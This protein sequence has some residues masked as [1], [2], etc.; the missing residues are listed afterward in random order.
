MENVLRQFVK[1]K[2]EN[3]YDERVASY[4]GSY[5]PPKCVELLEKRF[6][7]HVEPLVYLY[8]NKNDDI[9]FEKTTF[10]VEVGVKDAEH[11]LGTFGIFGKSSAMCTALENAFEEA[12]LQFLFNFR[13]ARDPPPPI[14]GCRRRYE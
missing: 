1:E 4:F 5:L 13:Y 9:G 8:V 14:V 6:T 7:K 2:A 10:R 11:D 3:E 12:T